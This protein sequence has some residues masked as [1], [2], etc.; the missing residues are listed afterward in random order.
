MM[1]NVLKGE[2]VEGRLGVVWVE[3]GC[4]VRKDGEVR[5]GLEVEVGEV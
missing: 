1:R 3:K 2:R 5:V 4:M